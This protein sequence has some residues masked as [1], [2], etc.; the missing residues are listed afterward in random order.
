VHKIQEYCN[1]FQ[2]EYL[3]INMSIIRMDLKHIIVHCLGGRTWGDYCESIFCGGL[4]LVK[5]L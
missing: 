3:H 1:V 5:P 2:F 4:I